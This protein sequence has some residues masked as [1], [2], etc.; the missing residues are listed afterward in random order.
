MEILKELYNWIE[1]GKV[2][3]TSGDYVKGWNDSIDAVLEH[4]K[5]LLSQE[6]NIAKL[7]R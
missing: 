4:M 1:K 5:K 3:Q 6:E 2:S 7:N